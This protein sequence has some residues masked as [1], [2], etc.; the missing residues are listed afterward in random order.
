[1]FVYSMCSECFVLFSDLSR[2]DLNLR[3]C[4]CRLRSFLLMLNEIPGG[5]IDSYV[6]SKVFLF[7]ICSSQFALV[8]RLVERTLEQFCHTWLVTLHGSLVQFSF[9]SRLLHSLTNLIKE[10][11]QLKNLFRLSKTG[12]N[13]NKWPNSITS[14][15]SPRWNF[16]KANWANTRHYSKQ[17]SDSYL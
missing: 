8:C 9:R 6:F 5:P 1:M 2:A 13:L 16:R 15:P 7:S 12:F 4:G 11:G 17:R 3:A 14:I 10:N